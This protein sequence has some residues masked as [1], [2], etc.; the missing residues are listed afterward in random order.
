V[1]LAALILAALCAAALCA[2]GD[3]LQTKPIPHNILE[4]M[5]ISPFPVYWAGG[6]FRGLPVTD[7]THDPSGAYSVQYGNCL[8]G[9]QGVCVA[10][11]RIVTSP[12]NSFLPGGSAPGSTSLLRGIPVAV[13]RGGRTIV[14]ATGSVV[15]DIYATTA[16]LASA[17]AQT[18]VPINAPGTPRGPL[19]ARLPDSG[20]GSR[21]LPSQ[22]P[23]TLGPLR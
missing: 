2:C 15:V 19:P 3:T 1:R 17:A 21:P 23:A 7:A 18:V 11:L 22:I 20:F 13:A 12:D 5:V 10:P 16:R 8:Q 4:S 9:G 6:S 14:I